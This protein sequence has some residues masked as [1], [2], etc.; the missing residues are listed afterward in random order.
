M[1]NA[2]RHHAS[3]SRTSLQLDGQCQGSD[4]HVLRCISY[5]W[6]CM[7]SVMAQSSINNHFYTHNLFWIM[8]VKSMLLISVLDFHWQK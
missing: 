3:F 4:D 8:P 1:C 6:T 2:Q 7:Q 5:L